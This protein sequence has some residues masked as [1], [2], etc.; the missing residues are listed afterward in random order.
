MLSDALYEA[1]K[2]IYDYQTPNARSVSP[3][4]TKSMRSGAG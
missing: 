4:G 1:D 2:A 3:F